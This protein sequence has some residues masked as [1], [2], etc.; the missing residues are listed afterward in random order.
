[1]CVNVDRNGNISFCV[2]Y[3]QMFFKHRFI[4]L[5]FTYCHWYCSIYLLTL[6]FLNTFFGVL[7]CLL[8]ILLHVLTQL[9]DMV[10]KLEKTFILFILGCIFAWPIRLKTSTCVYS[11]YVTSKEET[12]KINS[13]KSQNVYYLSFFLSHY[14]AIVY[15]I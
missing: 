14:S 13:E 6:L 8:F 2:C 15:E 1:M 11:L 12:K 4:Y 7:I 10:F 9:D 3:W 5:V